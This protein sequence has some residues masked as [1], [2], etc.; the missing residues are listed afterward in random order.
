MRADDPMSS[1]YF[2]DCTII[3]LR[4]VGKTYISEAYACRPTLCFDNFM[5]FVG[6]CV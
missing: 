3:M 1:K 2:T 6:N 5:S 4:E